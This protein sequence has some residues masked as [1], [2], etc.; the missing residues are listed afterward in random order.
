MLLSKVIP[1]LHRYLQTW[2][3]K[4]TITTQAHITMHDAAKKI[5]S[6]RRSPTCGAM[7]A[8]IA[9]RRSA[10]ELS[11]VLVTLAAE[12]SS[13]NFFRSSLPTSFS[14]HAIPLMPAFTRS[15]SNSAA[16]S[17][18]LSAASCRY[19]I[20]NT[21]HAMVS[22]KVTTKTHFWQDQPCNGSSKATTKTHYGFGE[23]KKLS[24]N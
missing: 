14:T 23:L 13:R 2:N 10:S 3:Q 9:V 22:S 17:K 1:S 16:G 11:R 24:N 20:A 7:Y 5:L 15:S 6:P 4:H 12:A 18:S 19:I 21:K 8:M